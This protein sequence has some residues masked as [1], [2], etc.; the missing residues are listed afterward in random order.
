MRIMDLEKFKNIRVDEE[1]KL[2]FPPVLDVGP[3]FSADYLSKE[4]LEKSYNSLK[5]I[6]QAVREGKIG[7]YVIMDAFLNHD[8]RCYAWIVTFFKRL[9]KNL[10]AVE[11][12]IPKYDH[13]KSDQMDFPPPYNIV[14]DRKGYRINPID[15]KLRNN[16]VIN[17]HRVEYIKRCYKLEDFQKGFP[18]WYSAS[19]TTIFEKYDIRTNKRIRIDYNKGELLYFIAG[20]SDNWQQ[21][22][23][24]PLEIDYVITALLFRN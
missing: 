13:Y 11:I 21:I 20:A 1:V 9:E 15:I 12:E 17:K 16:D 10:G 3:L 23:D 24:V 14:K 7:E 5:V 6:F 19:D 18:T 8:S 22:I 4:D 2:F